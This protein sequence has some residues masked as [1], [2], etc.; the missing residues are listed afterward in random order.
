LAPSRFQ[1]GAEEMILLCNQSE[2][3]S[4]ASEEVSATVEEMSAQAEEVTA[5]AQSLSAMA[6][7]LRAL[8][9]QFKVPAAAPDGEMPPRSQRQGDASSLAETRWAATPTAT[10]GG[11]GRE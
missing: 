8:V 7:E 6:Q 1:A 5:L 9:A 10:P 4:A 11:D 3:N 2:E